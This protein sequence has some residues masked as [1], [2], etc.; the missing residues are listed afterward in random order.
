[1]LNCCKNIWLK[2]LL[3]L[4]FRKCWH[5]KEK[6]RKNLLKFYCYVEYIRLR[7]SLPIKDNIWQHRTLLSSCRVPVWWPISYTTTR[8]GT[9]AVSADERSGQACISTVWNPSRR[10]Y[11]SHVTRSW[12]VGV[13]GE[14]LKI[15]EWGVV[16]LIYKHLTHT[17]H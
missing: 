2:N 4:I 12:I 17:L 16:I 15:P 7:F 14:Q 8:W 11:M 3:L 13:W 5:N 9:A 10:H 6:F 1:M